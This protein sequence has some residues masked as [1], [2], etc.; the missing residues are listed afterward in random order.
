VPPGAPASLSF[1]QGTGQNGEVHQALAVTIGVKVLD[2]KD[3][4]VPQQLINWVIV[5]GGGSTF[6]G[7]TLTN[8]Q[9]EAQNQW[10]LGDTAGIQSLEARIIDSTGAPIVVQRLDATATPGPLAVSHFTAETLFVVEGSVTTLPIVGADAYGNAV[11]PTDPVALDNLG[12]LAGDMYTAAGIG[13]ARFTL[14][15][16]TLITFVRLRDGHFSGHYFGGLDTWTAEAD[17]TWDSEGRAGACISPG[18]NGLG[19]AIYKTTHFEVWN[20]DSSAIF[21]PDPSSAESFFCVDLNGPSPAFYASI[22]YADTPGGSI[23]LHGE[24]LVFQSDSAG[25]LTFTRQAF[26]ADTIT[27]TH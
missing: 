12:N 20:A 10:T 16:D 7:A 5:K 6:V 25:V 23:G 4:A 21:S 17:L 3:Q 1:D 22:Y 13:R 18:A 27:V 19:R 9:G 26:P 8:D 14:P 24:Q 11:A 15:T 2:A